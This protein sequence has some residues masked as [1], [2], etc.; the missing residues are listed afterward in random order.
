MCSQNF[1]I[2]QMNEII[3]KQLS[4]VPNLKRFKRVAF[5]EPRAGN[6]V[7]M[8]TMFWNESGVKDTTLIPILVIVDVGTRFTKF[9]I[10]KTKNE[11][12]LKHYEDFK[13]ELI[14]K[15]PEAN[16]HTV[17]ITDAARELA[18]PFTNHPNVTHKVSKGMNKAVMAEVKI[19][20]LRKKLRAIELALNAENLSTNTEVHINRKTLEVILPDLMEDMNLKAAQLPDPKV[21][22]EGEPRLKPTTPVFL[23]NLHKFFPY[24]MKD[25]LRKKSYDHNWYMEPFRISQRRTINGVTKY[26][27]TEYIDSKVLKYWVYRDQIQPIDPRVSNEYIKNWYKFHLK[28][29][30]TE[31]F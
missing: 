9:Y 7:H 2:R 12:V 28:R 23:I 5:F 3:Q 25:V 6:Q 18:I 13:E 17:L 8:D 1:V 22:E 11:D 26:E 30:G 15:F 20:Q 21:H 19:G 10:Q 29:D 24:Q 31:F 4:A 16:P 27:L 14:K